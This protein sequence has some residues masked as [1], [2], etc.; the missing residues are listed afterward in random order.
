MEIH[1]AFVYLVSCECRATLDNDIIK[2]TK[3]TFPKKKLQPLKV[4]QQIMH[5]QKWYVQVIKVFKTCVCTIIVNV[6]IFANGR[7]EHLHTRTLQ[8]YTFQEVEHFKQF[9]YLVTG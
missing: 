5:I 7:K 8:K 2:N 3:R 6:I 1:I 9:V 4:Q